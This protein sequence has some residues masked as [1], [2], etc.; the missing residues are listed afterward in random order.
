MG[1]LKWA[2]KNASFSCQD[3]SKFNN[4]HQ[5]FH[6][7]FVL[8]VFASPFRGHRIFASWLGSGRFS[9]CEV[10]AEPGAKIVLRPRQ[11]SPKVWRA[12]KMYNSM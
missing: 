9:D 7:L 11:A 10:A 1:K 5:L 3:P 4:K 6:Q 2:T 8:P 12:W